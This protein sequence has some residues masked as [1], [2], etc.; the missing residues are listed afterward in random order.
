M[1]DAARWISNDAAGKSGGFKCKCL[2]ASVV[3]TELS[4]SE[5]VIVF[6]TYQDY[7]P[8]VANAKMASVDKKCSQCKIHN[9]RS[10]LNTFIYNVVTKTTKER[11]PLIKV[12]LGLYWFCHWKIGI[13]NEI[14]C[15]CRCNQC[16]FMYNERIGAP[17]TADP[18]STTVSIRIKY[19]D[20]FDL[21]Y[22]MFS[23][24]FWAET[25]CRKSR[26]TKCIHCS[27]KTFG[28]P[29]SETELPR[30]CFILPLIYLKRN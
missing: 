5:N 7:A 21:I 2:K 23:A 18:Y 30:L 17:I 27:F 6:P 15:N 20:K 3:K 19:Q 13:F 10:I 28:N 11:T 29:V 12:S 16:K 1:G 26:T 14:K 24:E 4:Q 8:N 22:W 9:L 25:P